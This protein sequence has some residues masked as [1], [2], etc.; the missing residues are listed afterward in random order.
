M[1]PGTYTKL[2][3][4]YQGLL[5]SGPAL[6]LYEICR[7]YATNPSRVTSIEIYEYWHSAL[8]GNP[9]DEPPAYKYFK[10][11]VLK[12]AIAEINSTTDIEVDLIEHKNGR[13]VERLQFYVEL[14]KQQ[15]IAFPAPPLINSEIIGKLITYGFSQQESNRSNCSIF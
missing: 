14:K 8:T 3:I 15:N 4:Y 5:R 13:K 2:S 9:R 6:A 1:S 10:R 11:D 7:R 12:P